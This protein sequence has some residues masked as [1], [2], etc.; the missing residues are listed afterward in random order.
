MN[1]NRNVLEARDVAVHFRGS[2]GLFGKARS[3]LKA[4]DGV[5]LTI[6]RNETVA[7]VG[8]SGCGKSTLSN[9]IVGLVPPTRGSIRIAGQGGVGRGAPEAQ[10][11]PATRSNDLS[12]PC[13]VA[14]STV[15]D[16][17]DHRRA[18]RG[19]DA[20]QPARRCGTALRIF[21]PRS[22]FGRSS[23]TAI[24]TSSPAVS[25][26][27]SSSRGRLRWN[28]SWSS[29]TSRSRRSTYPYARRY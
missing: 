6:R 14:R 15:I 1:E 5:D 4:V 10:R 18:A 22:D 27:V 28:P 2:T 23:R 25:A 8:E 3:V 7:L 16:R 29:A 24:R 26:S 12:G 21:S 20:S 11:H 9:A 13:S 17:R 19:A